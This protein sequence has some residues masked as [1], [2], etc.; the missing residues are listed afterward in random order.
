MRG[1]CDLCGSTQDVRY[2]LVRWRL[3]A[4]ATPFENLA[5]CTDRAACRLRVETRGEEWL[6]EDPEEALQS[7]PSRADNL[8]P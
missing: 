1:Q 8:R 3:G 7:P 6:V 4:T 2:A 5:R